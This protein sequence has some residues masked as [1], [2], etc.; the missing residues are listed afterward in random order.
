MTD[1]RESTNVGT[2]TGQT[3]LVSGELREGFRFQGIAVDGYVAPNGKV[4]VVVT[5]EKEPTVVQG[6]DPDKCQK[7]FINGFDYEIRVNP[8]WAPQKTGSGCITPNLVGLATHSDSFAFDAPAEPGSHSVTVE[9]VLPN[10]GESLVE[11]K[12]VT[13]DSQAS[14]DPSFRPED[15]TGITAREANRIENNMPPNSPPQSGGSGLVSVVLKNPVKS[16]IG[17][18]FVSVALR[19]AVG[20]E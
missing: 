10:R 12:Q 13:V 19:E 16:A 18:I 5:V 14:P 17:G 6:G 8:S 15:T 9:L 3:G 7:G 20:G 4:D 2:Q 1:Y 11:E